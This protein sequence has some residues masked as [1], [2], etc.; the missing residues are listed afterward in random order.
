MTFEQA[1]AA[2]EDIVRQLES[3]RVELDQSVG[4]YE[5]GVALK[6]HCEAKLQDAR[7]KVER[8]TLGPD[9]TPGSAPFDGEGG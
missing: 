1:L 8:I 3:G 9:G 2:L 5:R 4:A 7:M 6:R